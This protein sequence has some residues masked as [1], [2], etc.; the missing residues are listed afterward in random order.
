M[1][2]WNKFLL[3]IG[4]IGAIG[5]T[6]ALSSCSQNT[7]NTPTTPITPPEDTTPPP[8]E[9]VIKVDHMWRILCKKEKKV[10]NTTMYYLAGANVNVYTNGDI[11]L[12][13]YWIPQYVSLPTVGSDEVMQK[14][15]DKFTWYEFDYTSYNDY[16]AAYASYWFSQSNRIYFYDMGVMS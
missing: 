7:N 1:N 14:W 11:K 6:I 12:K 8:S 2:K 5:A 10:Q 16:I 4:A 15:T 3:P 13:N 9:E